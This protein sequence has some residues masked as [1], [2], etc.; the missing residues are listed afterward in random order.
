MT[1]P[2]SLPLHG[3]SNGARLVSVDGRTLPLKAT[4][5]IERGGFFHRLWDAL[6]L[7]FLKLFGKV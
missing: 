5:A 3:N 2:M 1:A 6:T 7:F 4:S